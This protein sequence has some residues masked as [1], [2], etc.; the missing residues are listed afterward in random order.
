MIVRTQSGKVF[1][2]DDDPVDVAKFLL[3][4]VPKLHAAGDLLEQGHLPHLK[5]NKEVEVLMNI[6]NRIKHN[7]YRKHQSSLQFDDDIPF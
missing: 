7:K 5:V 3:F 4:V 2:L 1:S 6:A